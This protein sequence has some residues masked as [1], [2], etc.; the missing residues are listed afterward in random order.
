MCLVLYIYIYHNGRFNKFRSFISKA[1]IH[2]QNME[3]T[4]CVLLTKN[5]GLIIQLKFYILQ[6]PT[7][8]LHMLKQYYFYILISNILLEILHK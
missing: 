8:I 6:C 2:A 5:T 4:K 1:P 7:I 3:Y